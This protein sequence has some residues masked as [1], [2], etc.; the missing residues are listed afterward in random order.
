[1]NKQLCSHFVYECVLCAHNTSSENIINNYKS[2][3]MA[4]RK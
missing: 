2:K 3:A 4:P 1:M